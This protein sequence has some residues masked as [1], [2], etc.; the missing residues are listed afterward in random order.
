MRSL[1]KSAKGYTVKDPT[2]HK[3]KEKFW[4]NLAKC[5]VGKRL[6]KLDEMEQ[7]NVVAIQKLDEDIT[8]SMI[9]A[10]KEVFGFSV[11]NGH[12]IS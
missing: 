8:R 6:I 12:P 10:N 1:L 5:H 9:S 3:Y 4:N 2:I 7:V 11:Y